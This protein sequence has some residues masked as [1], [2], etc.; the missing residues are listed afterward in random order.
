MSKRV[1]I[2][3]DDEGILEVASIVLDQ[4]G[5]EVTALST[6]ENIVEEVKKAQPDVV[7]MDLWMPEVSGETATKQLKKDPSTK[8]VPVIVVSANKDTEVIAQRA[9]S[10]AFICKPFDITELEEAVRKYAGK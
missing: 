4:A 2:C 8:H 6:A 3:D 7:L 9:G 1:L 10:D 5:Y